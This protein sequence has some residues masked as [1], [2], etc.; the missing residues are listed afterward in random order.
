MEFYRAIAKQLL[1][2]DGAILAEDDEHVML[3][4]RVPKNWLRNNRA[5]L[6]L[7]RAGDDYSTRF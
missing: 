4:V 5:L 2:C 3:T 7:L 1:D 6:G